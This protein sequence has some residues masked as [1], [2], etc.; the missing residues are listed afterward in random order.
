MK[1]HTRIRHARL[2]AELSIR[3]LASELGVS[4]ST[5]GHWETGKHA[6]SVKSLTKIAAVTRADLA[7][8]ASG[9]CELSLTMRV[10]DEASWKDVGGGVSFEGSSDCEAHAHPSV[11][12]DIHLA[13]DSV[14]PHLAVGGL[15]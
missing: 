8:L 5:V 2:R 4:H 13:A 3:E 12:R 6:P 11:H 10:I 14:A 9:L 1:L 15:A 7:W